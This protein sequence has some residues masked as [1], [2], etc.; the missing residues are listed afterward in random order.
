MTQSARLPTWFWGLALVVGLGMIGVGLVLLVL[1]FFF[2]STLEVI[3]IVMAGYGLLASVLGV[4]LGIAGLRG[5]RQLPSERFYPKRGWLSL[6]LASV[7]VGVVSLLVPGGA[8]SNPLFALLYVALIVLP[9]LCL[10]S[11]VSLAVGRDLAVTRRRGVLAIAGGASSILLVLPMELI[12][13]VVSGVLGT[14]IA[15]LIPGGPAE[16]ER[17]IS[18][19]QRWSQRP[20]VDETEVLALLTSPVVMLILALLLGVITPLIEEFGKTL[21]IGVMGHWVRPSVAA[22]FVWGVACGLGFAWFEGI[23]NGAMGLGGS[24]VWLGSAGVRFLATAMHGLTSGLLGLGW[25]W[26]RR[27][28]WWALPIAYGAAVIFHGLWNLNVIL[29]LGGIGLSLSS[30]EA[31][32]AVAMVAVLVQLVLILASF[33]G[34]FGLPIWLR[35]RLAAEAVQHDSA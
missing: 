31:G 18:L 17:L 26:A 33:A 8:Q 19:L 30:P 34:L 5:R 12:G 7:G 27:G 10:F 2:S 29:A 11:L 14:S 13:M 28:R 16:I 4:G 9:S 35:G 1:P 21:M 15:F 3:E 20:P 6:A 22:S 25:G 23:S 24:A 32:G